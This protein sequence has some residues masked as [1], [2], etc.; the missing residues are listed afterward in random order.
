[1]YHETFQLDLIESSQPKRLYIFCNVL[2]RPTRLS[3][4]KALRSFRFIEMATFFLISFQVAGDYTGCRVFACSSNLFFFEIFLYS[5]V[6]RS[7]SPANFDLVM[8]PHTAHSGS[9]EVP[10]STVRKTTHGRSAH[11]YAIRGTSVSSCCLLQC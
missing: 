1:M 11:T 4:S 8:S 5:F 10:R 6:P 7:P 9:R 2:R 3:T